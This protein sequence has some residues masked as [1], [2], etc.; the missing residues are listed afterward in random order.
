LTLLNFEQA[1]DGIFH[2]VR[3][4]D[5]DEVVHVD[6]SV[7]PVRDLETIQNE[8]C[9]KDLEYYKRAVEEEKKDVRKNPTMKLS[10]LFISTM[11]K[12]EAMLT[13]NKPIRFGE[14]SS[15]EVELIKEK[16]GSC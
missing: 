1:V 14:W 13:A 8:L 5:N 3:A 15:P 4:F 6:D 10:A 2:V 11:E 12:V 9:L 16:L 7:D